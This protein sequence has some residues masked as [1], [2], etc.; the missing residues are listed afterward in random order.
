[1]RKPVSKGPD[2]FALPPQP[3]VPGRSPR[4][5]DDDDIH[6]VAAAAP[7][8]TD[9]LSW[10]DNA[11]WLAGIR[12][13]AAG[14]FWEAHEVWEP[15][16]MRARPNSRERLL[17]QGVIQLANGALKQAMGRPVAARR[18]ADLAVALI[19]DSGAAGPGELMGLDLGAILKAARAYAAALGQHADPEPPVLPLAP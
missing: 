5:S 8:P 3:Y 2:D 17:V 1:M 19:A 4:P 12:L 11:A 18:L 15:V 10:A 13:Y 14:Y 7:D 6:R 9:P 16:W